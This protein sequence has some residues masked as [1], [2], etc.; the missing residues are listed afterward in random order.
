MQWS[1]DRNAGFSRADAARLY[2]PPISDPVYGYQAVNVEAQERLPTSLLEWMRRLIRVRKRFKAFGRGSLQ[3]LNVDNRRTLAYIRSY[4]EEVL[5][6]VVNLSRFVQPVQLDLS[7]YEGCRPI[8]LI[9]E[10]PFPLIGELPY[11]LTLGPH[12][13][14]WFRLEPPVAA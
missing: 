10:I 7:A 2:D 9:G 14:F 1:P 3:F 6:C 11:F 13:F 4:E 8:E 5:L 12:S